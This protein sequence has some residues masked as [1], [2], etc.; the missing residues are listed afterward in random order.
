MAGNA[1]VGALRVTLGLDSAQFSQGLKGAQTGLDRFASIAKAGALAIGSSLVAAGG[2]MALMMKGVIDDADEM[3]KMAQKIGIP[4]EELSR[5]RYAAQLADVD[6]EALSKAVKKLSTNMFEAGQNAT[7]PAAEA[8]AAL[9]VSVRDAEGR[10]L[11]ATEVIGALADRFAR[12]PDGVE[13]TA[14]AIKIFGRA[15][16][17]MIPLLNEGSAG[18]KELYAEAEKLGLALDEETGKAAERFND[19]LTRLGKT[20]DGII[21]KITAGMLPALS[22]LTDALANTSRN[23]NILSAVGEGLGKMMQVQYSVIAAVGGAFS[24]LARS[25]NTTTV[26]VG[27]LMKGD[28]A[29]ATEALRVGAR[30]ISASITG[31]VSNLRNIWKPLEDVPSVEGAAREVDGLTRSATRSGRATAQMSEEQRVLNDLMEDGRRTFEETRTP[32]EIYTARLAE[33]GNQLR[34]NAIDQETFNRAVRDARTAFEASDPS[35]QMMRQTREAISDA[36]A[37]AREIAQDRVDEAREL[38]REYQ[39]D[40]RD[41]TYDGVRGGL[42]AAADGDLGQYLAS[43]LRDALF[44]GLAESL[45]SLL[46]GARGSSSGGA[47]GWLSSVGS[48]AKNLFGGLPGFK[49]GGSFKVGGSGGLDSQLVAFKAT[50]GEMVDIKKPGQMNGGA[51]AVHVIP[52]PYFDVQVEKVASGPAAQAGLQSFSAARQAVPADLGRKSRFALGRTR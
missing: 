8:F 13:K 6:L 24:F 16:A 25:I 42:E 39:E 11:S 20:K 51:M 27:R 47:L 41:A 32:A 14:L 3:S 21:A 45:T 30:D 17:D 46:R 10:A 52:S 22:N 1:V 9:G 44:D 31:T 49:T 33:L 19:N 43:R 40:L 2:A 50:P 48:V 15:G 12:M 4:I 34:A 38:A 28:L 23:T 18:L 7:G 5:L 29:G 36:A 35:T 26:A 37:Q